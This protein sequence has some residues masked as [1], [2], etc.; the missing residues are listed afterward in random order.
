MSVDLTKG[1]RELLGGGTIGG[2]GVGAGAS[3]V[4]ERLGDA[5]EVSRLRSGLLLWSYAARALQVT[6]RDDHVIL[7]GVYFEYLPSGA[8]GA[9]RLGAALPDVGLVV[10]ELGLEWS[11]DPRARWIQIVASSRAH[12][13]F[14]DDLGLQSIQ[15]AALD[16]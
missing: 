4:R 8:G 15:L 16:V 12:V 3:A 13:V 10:A 9:L 7:I 14:D 6:L 5:E 1:A 2:I 11:S